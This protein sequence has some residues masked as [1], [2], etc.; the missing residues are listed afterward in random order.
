MEGPTNG[1][2]GA[3]EERL[4]QLE[5]TVASLVNRVNELEWILTSPAAPHTG[6]GD[7]NAA[8]CTP[9]APHLGVAVVEPTPTPM[10]RRPGEFPAEMSTAEL[11]ALT[12]STEPNR[13]RR[14]PSASPASA[15]GRPPGG[16]DGVWSRLLSPA[17]DYSPT[18]ERLSAALQHD[19]YVRT[20]HERGGAALGG[21]AH[22]D[23]MTTSQVVGLCQS[24]YAGPAALCRRAASH[25]GP[26]MVGHARP[27]AGLRAIR[28][29]NCSVQ[30]W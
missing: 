18:L 6:G 20:T 14:G 17:T 22:C 25:A 24:T 30:V 23:S 13:R 9:A 28:P 12:A 1:T 8:L 27:G 11:E 7:G 26:R 3:L 4:R 19:K 10:R 16:V 21:V 5:V 2:N 15:A 29:C